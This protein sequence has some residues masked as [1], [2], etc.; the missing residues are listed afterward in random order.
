MGV[1]KPEVGNTSL[2]GS[3]TRQVP[4]S[5]CGGQIASEDLNLCM[6]AHLFANTTGIDFETSHLYLADGI[7]YSSQ[8]EQASPSEYRTTDRRYGIRHALKPQRT[9]CSEDPGDYQ[10]APQVGRWSYS[11]AVFRD[12]FECSR[13]GPWG[14]EF[15]YITWCLTSE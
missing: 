14:E 10:F 13:D 3:L 5:L 7:N 4:N 12:R 6:T 2:S 1:E 9:V 8:R 11:E 15:E